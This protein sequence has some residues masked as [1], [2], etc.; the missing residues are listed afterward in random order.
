MIFS[1]NAA[2]GLFERLE[3]NYTYDPVPK[4]ASAGTESPPVETKYP[5]TIS[6]SKSLVEFHNQ[7]IVNNKKIF[8]RF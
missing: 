1:T 4:L 3:K 2:S 7:L 6:F 8:K 5:D